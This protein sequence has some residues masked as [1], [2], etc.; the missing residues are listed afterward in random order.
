MILQPLLLILIAGYIGINF[1]ADLPLFLVGENLVYAALYALGFLKLNKRLVI[2][3]LVV[4]SAFNAGRVSRSV[5]EPSG[6][7]APIAMGHLPLL[8]LIVAVMVLLVKE[9]V[10]E[11]VQP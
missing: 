1:F 6:E 10:E 3:F 11:Q 9:L 2:I 7:L 5:L 8:I 4:L